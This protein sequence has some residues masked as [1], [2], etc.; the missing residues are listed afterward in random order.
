VPRVLK[1]MSC[2]RGLMHTLPPRGAGASYHSKYSACVT[3]AQPKRI[4]GTLLLFGNPAANDATA[5]TIHTS[6]RAPGR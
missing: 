2:V 3:A 5:I 6:I 1:Q 4:A